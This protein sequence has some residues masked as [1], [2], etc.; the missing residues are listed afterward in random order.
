LYSFLQAIGVKCGNHACSILAASLILGSDR[1]AA[2]RKHIKKRIGA[3]YYLDVGSQIEVEAMLK[4]PK[5]HFS[6]FQELV[7][8]LTEGHIRTY[9]NRLIALAGTRRALT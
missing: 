3:Q 4:Q 1:T 6:D 8:S 9:R 2:I 5:M 7:S